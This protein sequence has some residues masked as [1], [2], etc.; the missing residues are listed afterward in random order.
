MSSSITTIKEPHL[1]KGRELDFHFPPLINAREIDFYFPT[2]KRLGGIQ[3]ALY[4][5]DYPNFL[6][7][8]NN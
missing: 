5:Q 6:L 3:Y 7:S 4:V 8:L 2:L 1:H